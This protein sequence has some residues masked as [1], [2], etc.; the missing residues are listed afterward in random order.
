MLT[1]TATRA[2]RNGVIVSSRA[3]NAGAS[4][5]TSTSGTSPDSKGLQRQRRH[6]GVHDLRAAMQ[7]DS[8]NQRQ[9]E[10]I[11]CDS[12]R[13]T[14]KQTHPHTPVERGAKSVEIRLTFEPGQ[15]RQQHRAEGDRYQPDGQ[16]Q[17]PIRVVEPGNAAGD[18]GRGQHGIDQCVDLTDRSGKHRRQQ[19]SPDLACPF[20]RGNSPSADAAGRAV[21]GSAAGKHSCA[22]PAKNTPQARANTGVSKC[23]V[24]NSAALISDRFSSTG[25]N[26]GSAKR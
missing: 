6:A 9:R 20:V 1:A 5:F 16:F 2:I 10:H 21:A 12:R 7:K 15:V 26:A 23:A 18:Q 8:G 11:E 24:A 17:Q 22:T 3:K 25:V 14:Q 13:Y 19:Q 4:T